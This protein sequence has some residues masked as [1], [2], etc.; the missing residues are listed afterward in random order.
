MK[1]TADIKQCNTC[2][3]DKPTSEFNRN[4]T[5]KDGLQSKCKSCYKS[6]HKSYYKSN[7]DKLTEQ[8]RAYYEANKEQIAERQKTYRAANKEKTAEYSKAYREVNKE[9]VSEYQKAYHEANKE[10]ILERQKAYREANKEQLRA[11]YEDNREKKL[12]Y[13]K[14]YRAANKEQKAEYNKAYYEANPEKVAELKAKQ[15]ARK[16]N[17]IPKK[18]RDCPLEKQRLILIYKLRD[19][20]TK[21]TGTQHHVDHMWPLIDGGPHWSGNL[22]IITAEENLSKH[23]SV[24]PDIRATIKEGLRNARQGC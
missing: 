7:K 24:C 11:Y 20:M 10:Q 15:R 18:F 3:T 5:K 1:G 13:Q 6:Y 9:K 2:K 17:A 22:Q 23:A 16:R 4:R 8:Q 14:A 19:V 21:A 12:E